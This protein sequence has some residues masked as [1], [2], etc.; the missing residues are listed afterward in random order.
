[1][2]KAKTEHAIYYYIGM[3]IVIFVLLVAM[4]HYSKSKIPQ[5]TASI[6]KLNIS[7]DT[8]IPKNQKNDYNKNLIINKNNP[9]NWEAISLG[10]H[11]SA[12]NSTILASPYNN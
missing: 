8:L 1:M 3:M 4:K 7:Q 12:H 5:S 6:Q 9:V 11:S 2:F 10:G